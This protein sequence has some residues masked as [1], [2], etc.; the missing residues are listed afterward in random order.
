MQT[1]PQGDFVIVT[2]EGENPENAFKSF[3]KT[4]DEFTKWFIK[5]VKEIH[6]MDLTTPPKG[7]LPELIV[8]SKEEV[9]QVL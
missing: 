7:T 5:E 1:T 3:A 9:Y 6:G 4:E 2:L 8:D